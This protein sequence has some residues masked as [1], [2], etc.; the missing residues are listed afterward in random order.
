MTNASGARSILATLR[1]NKSLAAWVEYLDDIGNPAVEVALPDDDTLAGILRELD[2][3]EEDIPAAVAAKP[4]PHID[5]DLWWLLERSVHSL[6]AT[7]GQVAPPPW[8]PS[9]DDIPGMNP[10]FFVHVFVA[11]LPYTRDYHVS[12]GIPDHIARE[13]LADL[14]RNVRVNRKRHGEGGLG[15]S[16][17]LMLHFRGMIYQ[18]GRLQFERSLMRGNISEALKA[19]GVEATRDDVVLSL[20][21]PD[22]LGPM[23]PESIDDSIGWARSFFPRHFPE[24]RYEYMVCHS[25]L[26]DP[27]LKQYLSPESNII[28]FQ[29]RFSL[30]EDTSDADRSVI[31]FVFGPVPDDLDVLPQR[32]SLERAVVAHLKAG[33]HWHGRNGW[34][35]LE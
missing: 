9:P 15:V 13:T 26:L 31:Q 6:V 23:S 5:P 21:I 33:G 11:T 4:D 1:D 20:H 19:R 25:W 7:M 29:N 12:R 35:R 10:W 17:W 34:F 30:A 22:F 28:R 24:E 32:T 3:P 18:L 16:F 2:V 27:Q 14:G 8:F